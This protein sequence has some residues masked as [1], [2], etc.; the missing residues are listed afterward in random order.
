MRT[1]L[2]GCLWYLLI[3]LF[4]TLADFAW[5]NLIGALVTPLLTDTFIMQVQ[6]NV[7]YSSMVDVVETRTIL[8]HWKNAAI[9]VQVKKIEVPLFKLP[10]FDWFPRIWLGHASFFSIS[11]ILFCVLFFRFCFRNTIH[12]INNC[13]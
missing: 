11:T 5:I 12:T 1:P 7:N 9:I 3:I 8:D 10:K 4:K 13:N 2:D 6:K